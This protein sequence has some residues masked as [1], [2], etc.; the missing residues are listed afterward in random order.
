[1]N[2]FDARLVYNTASQGYNAARVDAFP[3]SLTLRI[4]AALDLAPG[5][6]VLDVA[7]G[8]GEIALCAAQKRIPGVHI[9]GV[10]IAEDMLTIARHR[11]MQHGLTDI[12]FEKADMERLP[13]PDAS[14]NAIACGFAVFFAHDI[15]KAIASFW[16][17]LQPGGRLV[18]AT[19]GRNVF[20]PASGMFLDLAQE[21]VP[22]LDVC[23]PWRAT[24]DITALTALCTAAGVTDP[25]VRHEEYASRLAGPSDWWPLIAG[26]GFRSVVMKLS[27]DTVARIRH[28]QDRW[29]H[30]QQ[31]TTLT[32]G[33]NFITATKPQGETRRAL[34]ALQEPH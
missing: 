22:G 6:R 33:I 15:T 24:E 28:Q 26:S 1:M 20:A 8:T 14:F 17:L 19:L 4:T 21:Y 30:D 18:L 11:A 31:V 7:C 25:A 13:Y 34:S 2:G 3:P 27:D 16:R 32:S 23:L 10:D 12:M 5:D 29:M 9:T